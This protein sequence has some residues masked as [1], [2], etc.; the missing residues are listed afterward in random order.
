MSNAGIA[1]KL[2]SIYRLNICKWLHLQLNFKGVSDFNHFLTFSCYLSSLVPHPEPHRKI[3]SCA[4]GAE[5][6]RGAGG[7]FIPTFGKTFCI[8]G[9]HSEIWEKV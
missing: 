1:L 9:V 7:V 8:F 4:A 3:V 5:I 6:T 2:S